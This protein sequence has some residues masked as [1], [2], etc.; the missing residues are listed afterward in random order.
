MVF[1]IFQRKRYQFAFLN[2]KINRPDTALAFEEKLAHF[3]GTGDR[4][5]AVDDGHVGAALVEAGGGTALVV[6]SWLPHTF[7]PRSQRAAAI[8]EKDDTENS[9][10]IFE[11]FFLQITQLDVATESQEAYSV[12][13]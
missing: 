4:E 6:E 8:W 12:T 3:F 9:R 10:L 7:H 5:P 2:R 1:L 13:C 11:A